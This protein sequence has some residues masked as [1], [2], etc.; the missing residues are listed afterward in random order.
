M[1]SSVFISS[2]QDSNPSIMT[3]SFSIVFVNQDS[4]PFD[5][6]HVDDIFNSNNEN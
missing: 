6:D 2:N 3:M 4:N 1:L 5:Y